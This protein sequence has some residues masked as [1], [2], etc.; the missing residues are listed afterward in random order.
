MSDETVAAPA[1]EPQ[2]HVLGVE[3][4]RI[5]IESSQQSASAP[6]DAP[7][8]PKEDKP[9]GAQAVIDRD[10][11]RKNKRARQAEKT[12]ALRSE[13]DRAT[14]QAA[15]DSQERERIAAER[16]AL[17]EMPTEELLRRRGESA[18]DIIR[19]SIEASSPEGQAKAVR[20]ELRAYQE[21]QAARERAATVAKA[22]R[23]FVEQARDTEK[24]PTL[25][26]LAKN[27][28]ATLV[29]DGNE[30]MEAAFRRTGHYPSFEQA[31]E[32]LEFAYA[33]ALK[34]EKPRTPAARPAERAPVPK[35]V[36]ELPWEEQRAIILRGVR[37][38]DPAPVPKNVGEMSW[39]DQRAILL[40]QAR[41]SR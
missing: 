22:E 10:E 17:E 39:E 28:T 30:V 8:P 32:Y 35:D 23:D 5:A 37:A 29:R 3:A 36:G 24:Y 12:A 25:A 41:G 6:S 27:R 2:S 1:P 19:R 21:Q 7:L 4:A 38:A 26:R 9:E 31:L 15:W 34:E 11:R 20:A 40:R 33:G 13:I 18:Q 16:R 14:R